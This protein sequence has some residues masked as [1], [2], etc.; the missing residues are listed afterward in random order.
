MQNVGVRRSLIRNHHG[1]RIRSVRH[2][3]LV[4]DPHIG[5]LDI[6]VA[7]TNAVVGSL[8]VFDLDFGSTN[9]VGQLLE[10]RLQCASVKEIEN[11][12]V[13][14]IFRRSEGTRPHSA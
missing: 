12:A 5:P 6:R 8:P 14:D 9:G 2:D 7:E 4:S 11:R 10:V 13:L 3:V 1:L